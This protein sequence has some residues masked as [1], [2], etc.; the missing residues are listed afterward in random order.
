LPSAEGHLS[1]LMMTVAAGMMAGGSYMLSSVPRAA[2]GFVGWIF[3]G[4]LIGLLRG[5]VSPA[6]FGLII[7]LISY[8]VIMIR[9]AYWNYGNYLRTWLQQVKLEEQSKDLQRQKDTVSVLLK[10]FEE[11]ASDCLWEMDPQRRL[12][13]ISPQLAELFDVSYENAGIEIESILVQN[14][15]AS[16]R[17]I[18][19]IEEERPFSEE[20]VRV[21]LSDRTRWWSLSGKPVFEGDV[22]LGYRGVAS[23]VTEARAAE[24]RIAYLAHFDSLTG[25]SNRAHF[26]EALESCL[27]R[28]DAHDE[29]FAVASLDLDLFKSI[30]DVHG[31]DIGD[32]VLR[33][34]G[35]ML[36]RTLGEDAIIARVGGDEFAF[37]IMDTR[38]RQEVMALCDLVTELFLEPFKVKHIQASVGASIGVAFCPEDATELGPLQKCADLALYRAKSSGRRR[39]RYF[40]PEMDSE[41]RQRRTLEIELR[42]AINDGQFELYYQPLVDSQTRDIRSFETLLR[43]NH[44]ERGPLSPDEFIELTEQTGLIVGIGEWVMREAL[45]EAATWDTEAS[46]SIN[47]S[48]IQIKNSGLVGVVSQ[49]IS[50]SGITPERVELEITE[51]VL[52]DDSEEN[53]R[54]LYSLKNLGV[55]IALDDFG[56][57]YSS[58][59]YLRSFPFDKIKIDKSFVQS[60]ETSDE[61]RAIVRAVTA[62]AQSLGMRSTAE[63]VESADQ[64]RELK[65]QG[66]S[67]LQGFYF[68]EPKTVQQ[69]V[70]AG[71]IIRKSQ[72]VEP[73]EAEHRT[74]LNQSLSKAV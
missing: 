38:S 42:T 17:L 2:S 57:G 23:D 7:L 56:T 74:Q 46:I 10:D 69:L 13:N 52:L 9:S 11:S 22:L 50:R 36:R 49:A 1:T 5:G 18:E 39:A 44:P 45:Q 24:E 73:D 6:E 62:L 34:V 12:I 40:E 30:N 54:R 43:W 25:L 53:L 58:L 28:H 15:K 35:Q 32:E 63:G 27:Y 65:K 19:F 66:C 51:S 21:D 31:H 60:M 4:V 14:Q 59:S 29:P 72:T 48:P 26:T 70:A 3:L 64:V 20:L 61:C 37:I 33:T 8:T 47:L 41:A 67:E 68:S 16:A 55:R 71:M